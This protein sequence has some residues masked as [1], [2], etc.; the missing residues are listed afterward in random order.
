M[1]T[2]LAFFITGYLAASLVTM[3]V[4]YCEAERMERK[5]NGKGKE[6]KNG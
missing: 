4:V 6:K 1:L 2:Q 5:N 3:I